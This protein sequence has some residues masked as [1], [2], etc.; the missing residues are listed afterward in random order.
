MKRSL[1]IVAVFWCLS[2]VTYAQSSKGAAKGFQAFDA[3]VNFESTIK[4][5]HVA[6]E[7]G[8]QIAEKRFVL[9]TGT[10][11]SI[12]EGKGERPQ[13][14][15][16]LVSGEWIS[17]DDVRSYHVAIRFEGED[18]AQ[19]FDRKTGTIKPGD[20]LIVVAQ[21]T[22]T[23]EDFDNEKIAVLTGFRIRLFD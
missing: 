15:V 3:I 8:R 16:E 6:M 22:G 21:N 11:G 9:L 14:T 10:V 18:Y 5:F 7:S 12:V 4:D 2:A 19:F 20:R 13:Y 17:T 23:Q 1:A